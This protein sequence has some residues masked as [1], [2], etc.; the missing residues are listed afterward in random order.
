MPSRHR[1]A[2]RFRGLM[3]AAF[4]ALLAVTAHGMA[5]GRFPTGGTAALL[6]VLAAGMGAMVS[7]SERTVGPRALL[8][9][10]ALGQLGG[11]LV[12]SS[13]GHHVPAAGPAVLI[14][15]PVMLL[16]HAAAVALGAI[17]VAACERLCAALSS[18]IRGCGRIAQPQSTAMPAFAVRRSDHPQRRDLLIAASISHR[19]PPAGVA[20]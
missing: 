19:G 13:G 16:A 2:S 5:S 18:A 8:G 14:P 12:L 15:A 4:T 7:A 11:H 10:L 3:V 20:R 9:V 17:L 6:V 1:S